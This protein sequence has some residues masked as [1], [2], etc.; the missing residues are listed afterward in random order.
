MAHAWTEEPSSFVLLPKKTFAISP[1]NAGAPQTVS[2]GSGLSAMQPVPVEAGADVTVDE[3]NF[4]DIVGSV[5]SLEVTS[6]EAAVGE[7]VDNEESLEV[8]SAEV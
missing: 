6:V 7:T 2:T 5:E 1:L 3:A 8:T 4:D